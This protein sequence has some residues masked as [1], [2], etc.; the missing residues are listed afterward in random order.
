HMLGNQAHEGLQPPSDPKERKGLKKSPIHGPCTHCG[1]SEPPR[2]HGA[3]SASLEGSV[4]TL[5][6]V[7]RLRLARGHPSTE[8]TSGHPFTHPPYGGIKC[9][10]LHHGTRVRQ[11]QA[12]SLHSGSD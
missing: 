8:R 7:G 2:T 10:R 1:P 12:T 3:I 4:P 11:H 5:E 6:H 9:S